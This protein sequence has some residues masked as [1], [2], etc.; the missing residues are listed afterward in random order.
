[1]AL[2]LTRSDVACYQGLVEWLDSGGLR[3][4]L[5]ISIRPAL[6]YSSETAGGTYLWYFNFEPGLWAL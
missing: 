2:C 6:R 1:M 5:P 4:L 3:Y